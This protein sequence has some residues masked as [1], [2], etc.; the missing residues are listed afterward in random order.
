MTSGQTE[1]RGRGDA[2]FVAA[3][4]ICNWDPNKNACQIIDV[5][6]PSGDSSLFAFLSYLDC[7]SARL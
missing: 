1:K 4:H 6:N 3:L 7:I 2:A 5:V